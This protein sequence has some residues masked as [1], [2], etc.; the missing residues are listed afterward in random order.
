MKALVQ[1]TF[2]NIAWGLLRPRLP[3]YLILYV[4]NV[5][6]L[7]CRMCF[8]WEAMQQEKI[9]LSL[10]E[11]ERI[12]CSFPH[13][14]QLTLTGGEPSLREDLPEIPKIFSQKSCLA[15]CTIVTNGMASQR[16]YEQ[17]RVMVHEN[18]A[19]DFRYAISIDGIGDEHDAIRGVK[20]C[21]ANALETLELLYGLREKVHNLWVDITTVISNYNYQKIGDIYHYVLRNSRVDN[22][23]FSYVRGNPRQKDAQGVSPSAYRQIKDIFRQDALGRSAHFLQE[24]TTV[25][26]ELV[27]DEVEKELFLAT[28]RYTCSA[29]RKFIEIY[30]DGNVVPCEILETLRSR[31]EALLGNIKDFDYDIRKLLRS[32]KA[33]DVIASIRTRRCHCTF[34]CPKHMDIMYNAVFYPRIIRELIA[35]SLNR[36]SM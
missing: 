33:Q 16:I 20:G 13:L 17:A 23:A 22:H 27:K 26:R 28:P 12:A 19:V 10:D 21:F 5:C 11:I 3:S 30:P 31:E 25:I 35:S 14:L 18:P 24:P 8:Y 32:K 7:Q 36:K 15:K 9:E 29:G 1:R 6:Q 34:E 2:K 4:N